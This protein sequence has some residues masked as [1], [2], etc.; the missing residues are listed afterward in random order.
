M[1]DPITTSIEIT[2]SHIKLLQ[3]KQAR[4]TKVVSYCDVQKITVFSDKDISKLLASMISTKNVRSNNLVGV[5]PR[6]FAIL[7]HI[8]LPSQSPDEIKKM[9]DLQVANDVPYAREDIVFD[10]TVVE[11]GESGH[12]KVL[13]FII[14]QEVVNR[15]LKL[16]HESGLYPNKLTI[17]SVGLSEW[18]N[19][20]EGQI[21]S[22]ASLPTVL[23]YM[24][25]N[26][27]E[28]CFC[29]N[30]KLYFSRNINYGAKDLSEES[31]GLFIKQ[32]YLTM[33]TYKKEQMGP[34]IENIVLV[35]TV[36]RI[37][38]IQEELSKES[39]L[40]VHVFQPS[41]HLPCEK[42]AD[43]SSMWGESG[44]SV[45]VGVGLLFSN[46]EK[47]PNF[48]PENFQTT[49]TAKQQT[50]FWIKFGFLIILTFLLSV[51]A[52]GIDA[53]KNSDYLGQVQK[54]IAEIKPKSKK[55]E[56]QIRKMK[57]IDE[58]L[59]NRVSIANLFSKLH[60]LTPETVAFRSIDINEKGR[61]LIHG[62]SQEGVSVSKFQGNLVNSSLFKDV[63]LQYSNKIKIF[64]KEMIDFKILCQIARDGD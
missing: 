38:L 36:S 9:I 43:I 42:S 62:F 31:V 51:A 23:V 54:R 44:L 19:F 17:S 35:S 53:Y 24:D 39:D 33:G 25:Q 37:S 20:N 2:D 52:F 5:I 47:L 63:N 59:Y 14:H 22:G 1:K 55:A 40:P 46:I 6:R 34:E 64:N 18:L 58:K 30:K 7:K 3:C 49:E 10:Y 60:G 16:F 12:T 32:F 50:K 41:D 45:L 56:E 29:A 11:K 28:I 21:K 48:I 15:Y 27:A 8:T 57:I 13:A 26:N 61:I 4:V